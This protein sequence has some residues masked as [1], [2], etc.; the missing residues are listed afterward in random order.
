MNKDTFK[1]ERAWIEINTE[2]LQHNVNALKEAMPAKCEL[3]AVVKA[4]AY[5]HGAIIIATQLNKMGI[6]AFAVATIEEGIQL[7]ECGICGEI[8]ILGYTSV[9]RAFELKK[10]NLTQTLISF[11]YAETLNN[12][13][14]ALKTH[15]KID[16]GMHR[17]GISSKEVSVVKKIF[18]M[19]NLKVCGIFTHLCCSD[20][21][22]P[23]DVAF[24]KRQ[25]DSFYKLVNA[26]KDS[27]VSIPKLHIQSSYGLLN[28]PNLA[29]DY[30]RAGI[31]LYGVLS[32]PG[33]NTVL[34]LDLHPVLSLK[35]ELY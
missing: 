34:K 11:E 17:L 5:G 12:Q 33:D 1:T 30:V 6:K 29:C 22:Q 16:T 27:G 10:Y 31:A 32:S 28:Y 24:T 8:L 18:L 26:L 35:V 9:S 14:I 23:D 4:Q 2:N 15:I 3:M 13:G 19:K 21:R 25:I 7:R 20:S